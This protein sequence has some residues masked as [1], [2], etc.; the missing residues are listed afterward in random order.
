MDTGV[1]IL[2][3]PNMQRVFA[4]VED[5]TVSIEDKDGHTMDY[6]IPPIS[7]DD[8]K[9][10]FDYSQNV[11]HLGLTEKKKDGEEYPI[12]HLWIHK[13]KG[14]FYATIEYEVGEGGWFGWLFNKSFKHKIPVSKLQGYMGFI[15]NDEALDTHSLK[16][17]LFLIRHPNEYPI[18]VYWKY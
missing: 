18:T 12:T 9:V 15:L 1:S 10:S 4:G 2:P 11:E 16:G 6:V 3:S 7:L 17:I 8:L 5:R 14:N 13:E